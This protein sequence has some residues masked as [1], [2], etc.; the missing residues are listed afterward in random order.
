MPRVFTFL[1]IA[2]FMLIVKG[3]TAQQQLQL[4]FQHVVGNK[5]LQLF[6]QTYHNSF[7]EPFTVYRFRYYVSNIVLYNG[8]QNQ[9]IRNTY[10]L[11]DEDD[12]L[13]KRITLNHKLDKVTAIEFILGVDSIR[14]I[15]GVQTG[16]LDPAKG[17][18]WTWNTGY[19][20][21][22]LEGVSDSCH[23]P[24]HAFALEPGGFRNG[25]NALRTVRL[26]IPVESST[27]TIIADV[28]KWFQSVH[29]LKL[30]NNPSC[31]RPGNLAMQLADNYA[32]MF[33]VQL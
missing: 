26:N 2:T 25:E 16:A 6:E 29:T 13:S 15:S 21:A 7:G 17:M 12:S 8:S 23:T 30:A 22:K 1:F 5:P 32:T 11:I 20:F 31:H 3:A 9:V 24:G 27:I 10:F 19:I 18:F 14:N 28:L 4:Q 33:S